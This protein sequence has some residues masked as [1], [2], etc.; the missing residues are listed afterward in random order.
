MKTKFLKN[1]IRVIPSIILGKLTSFITFNKA[2]M[3]REYKNRML[4]NTWL[5]YSFIFWTSS[6][7]EC[8]NS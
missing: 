4:V 1:H 7:R 5:N 6:N 2:Y 8:D 3:K